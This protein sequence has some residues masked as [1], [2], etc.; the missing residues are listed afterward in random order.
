MNAN[1]ADDITLGAGEPDLP[2]PDFVKAAIDRDEVH[3]TA[4]HGTPDPKEAV[5]AN[6]ARGVSS[7]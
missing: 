3:Y 7:S 5:R 4:L 6:F 2:T 1:G